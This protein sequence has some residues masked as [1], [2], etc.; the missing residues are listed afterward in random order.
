MPCLYRTDGYI[1]SED[2]HYSMWRRTR[3]FEERIDEY[4]VTNTVYYGKYALE[5]PDINTYSLPANTVNAEHKKTLSELLLYLQDHSWL[6]D[7]NWSKHC[8][9][10]FYQAE[11]QLTPCTYYLALWAI[12]SGVRNELFSEPQDAH[13]RLWMMQQWVRIFVW[14]RAFFVF[15]ILEMFFL[16][17][18]L[19]I[20]RNKVSYA[21]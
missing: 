16:A 10:L 19:R 1:L 15:R 2:E 6:S 11:S 21:D 12:G 4:W 17:P 18:L 7:Q 9:S 20:R 5:V 13:R 8:F 3:S 14:T